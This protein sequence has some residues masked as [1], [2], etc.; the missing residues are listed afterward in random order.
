MDNAVYNH[1][2]KNLNELRDNQS[3]AWRKL[4]HLKSIYSNRVC[5]SDDERFELEQSQHRYNSLT[6]RIYQLK[7]R[8][9]TFKF[10]G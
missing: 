3:E 6:Q 1:I 8:L 2:K 5:L 4:K 9:I 7:E 10:T